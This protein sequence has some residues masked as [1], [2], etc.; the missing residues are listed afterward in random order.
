MDERV[1]PDR[2]ERVLEDFAFLPG[3]EERGL[4]FV[5]LEKLI[6][7]DALE[8]IIQRVSDD[9]RGRKMKSRDGRLEDLQLQI[10][11]ANRETRKAGTA[12]A[13]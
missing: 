7:A 10:A 6:G 3:H 5:E 13:K 8:M 1:F 4:F 9:T 12:A 11:K 2:I